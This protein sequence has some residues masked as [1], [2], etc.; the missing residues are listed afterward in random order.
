[1]ASDFLLIGSLQV[2]VVP[3]SVSLAQRISPSWTFTMLKAAENHNPVP[4]PGGLDVK[5]GPK[6]AQDASSQSYS[7]CCQTATLSTSL[8][9]KCK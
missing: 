2:N 5:K 1:V 6:I 4:F 9:N 3:K 7:L 8:K